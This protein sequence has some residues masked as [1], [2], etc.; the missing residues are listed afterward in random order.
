VTQLMLSLARKYRRRQCKTVGINA[1][2]P[3][4]SKL[5]HSVERVSIVCVFI[6]HA[7]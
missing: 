7:L 4:F 6:F 3:L 5:I 2:S 1:R